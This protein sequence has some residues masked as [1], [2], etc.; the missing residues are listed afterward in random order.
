MMA[1]AMIVSLVLGALTLMLWSVYY[2][3]NPLSH[4]VESLVIGLAMGFALYTTVN[5]LNKIWITPMMDGNWLLIIP[6]ILGLMLYAV[7]FKKYVYL[8]RIAL[9]A[10][11]GTGLGFATGRTFPVLILGQ[12]KGLGN[13]LVSAD[14]LGIANWLIILVATITTLMYFTFTREQTGVFGVTSKIGRYAIMIGFGTIFGATIW[15]NHVFVIDRAAF[16][17]EPPMIYLIPVAF[18]VILVDIYLQRQKKIIS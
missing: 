3:E 11:I 16:F 8:S 15:G 1:D 6:A 13:S 7:F 10:I 14:A 12:I 17:S 2:R 4:L 5:T 9:S 18:A